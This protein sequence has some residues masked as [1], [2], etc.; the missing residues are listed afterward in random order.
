MAAKGQ[1]CGGITQRR[2]KPSRESAAFNSSRQSLVVC[3]AARTLR[4][5]AR[6]FH[7][8]SA[9][10]EPRTRDHL[11]FALLYREATRRSGVPLE[12]PTR[13]FNLPYG[14]R[15]VSR[16]SLLLP[17]TN[18]PLRPGHCTRGPARI[19]KKVSRL[20]LTR[21]SC[22]S[23]IAPLRASASVVQRITAPTSAPAAVS[24]RA[25]SRHGR[26][27]CRGVR[28]GAA[29]RAGAG[30]RRVRRVRDASRERRR[31]SLDRGP[32]RAGGRP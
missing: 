14:C 12:Q 22:M 6:R 7:P 26:R 1:S 29:R 25:S 11:A 24:G 23:P 10:P 27:R 8:E 20:R 15:G 9:S 3:L 28:R 30:R 16:T 5:L 32:A 19:S 21:E 13:L 4:I 2:H 17:C 31:R 18:E